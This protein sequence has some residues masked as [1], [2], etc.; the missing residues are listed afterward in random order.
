MPLARYTGAVAVVGTT[1]VTSSAMAAAV[2]NRSSP[3]MR[4]T[5]TF[6]DSAVIAV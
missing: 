2:A 4:F 3:A 1:A 6:G 5:S